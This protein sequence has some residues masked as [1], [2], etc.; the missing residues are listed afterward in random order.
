MTETDCENPDFR[1]HGISYE[2]IPFVVTIKKMERYFPTS[3]WKRDPEAPQGWR[4][5]THEG[6]EVIEGEGLYGVLY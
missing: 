2:Q 5:W 4:Q 3:E 6:G 1:I